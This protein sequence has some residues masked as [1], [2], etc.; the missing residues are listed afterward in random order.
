MCEDLEVLT[1]VDEWRLYLKSAAFP[2]VRDKKKRRVLDLT[3][4]FDIET[5][6][7]LEDGFAYSFQIN[8]GGKNVLLRYVEDFIAVVNSILEK[9]HARLYMHVHNLGYE[10]FYLGSILRD[11]FGIESE[12]RTS[13]TK[14]IEVITTAG[15]VFRD[16]L[17]LFQKSLQGAT[18]GCAHPKAAHDLDYTIYRTPDTLL[19]DL[20]FRYCIYDVQ[21]LYEAIERLKAERGF[22]AATLPLT[23]TRIVID[24]V[25]HKLDRKAKDAMNLLKLNKQQMRLAYECAAGGD[26]HGNRHYRGQK[27][28]NCNSVDLKS[29]HPSQMLLEKYPKGTVTTL[30]RNVSETQLQSI[31]KKGFGWLGKLYI[32]DFHILPECPDPII[33]VSKCA[34]WH[35]YY[36]VDNGRLI[37]AKAAFVYMDSNDYQRFIEGYDY[38]KIIGV[39]IITFYLDYLPDSFTKGVYGFFEIKEEA[40]EGPERRFAKICIN[41]IYGACAQ[42]AVRDSYEALYSDEGVEVIKTRWKANLAPMTDDEVIKKQKWKFPYLWGIWTASLTRLALWKAIKGVGWRNAVYWDTDSVKFIGEVPAFIEEY[43]A[44]IVGKCL[45]RGWKVPIGTLED[46][47]SQVSYGY[48]EFKFLR[49]K[50]YAADAYDKKR[51]AY[52]F[53]ATISGVGKEEGRVLGEVDELRIGKKIDPAGGQQL[54]YVSRGIQQRSWGRSTSVAS[55]IFM[56]PRVYQVKDHEEDWVM[57]D[58][59]WENI[60]C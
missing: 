14:V 31:I 19:D 27:L 42:K 47:Y 34:D 29:A 6:N 1:S 59:E 7:L 49:A 56:E 60:S 15:V 23:N 40:E 20:E 28:Y 21:G 43:N 5:T 54:T 18:Q 9:T 2:I 58:I 10:W 8:I 36:G 45:A 4:T 33:S 30:P 24:A 55:Y 11:A 44:E 37:G 52:V 57:E 50:C 16:S 13:K 32:E 53:S 26:T 46:E 3:C 22:N 25:D 17:K 51:K 48:R 38:K 12:L 35:E 39:E 41:T